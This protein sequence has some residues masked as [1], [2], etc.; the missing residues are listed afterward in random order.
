MD[1]LPPNSSKDLV[2]IIHVNIVSLL[3]N[4]DAFTNF[5]NKFQ[6]AVDIICLSETRL[7]DGK[8]SYCSLPGY[9]LFCNNSVTRAGGSAIYVSD[10]LTCSQ[11]SQIKIKCNGCEDVWVKVNL[12]NNETLVLGLVHKHPNDIIKNFEDAF[13]SVIKSFKSKQNYIVMGDFKMNYDRATT[14]QNISDYANHI[15]SAGCEQLINKPTRVC[16]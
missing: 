10:R 13:I 11:L 4:F 9:R 1:M 7:N 3:K 8:L 12:H 14:Q 5:L 16:Q 15:N 6:K 2:T